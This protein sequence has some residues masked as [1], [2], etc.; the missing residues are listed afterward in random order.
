MVCTNEKFMGWG[1]HLDGTGKWKA[2][3]KKESGESSGFINYVGSHS[4]NM[5]F[6]YE[7]GANGVISMNVHLTT[8]RKVNYFWL[9]QALVKLDKN[10]KALPSD[11]GS[12]G[13]PA[14]HE[15]AEML[16]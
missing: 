14:L 4:K 3:K 8:N 1:L 12:F 15:I 13:P 7:R 10:F 6:A 16:V 9:L 5:L 2:I 11:Q